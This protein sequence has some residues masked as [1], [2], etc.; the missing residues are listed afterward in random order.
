MFSKG[1]GLENSDNTLHN[2]PNICMCVFTFHWLCPH[3]WADVAHWLY[4]L[5]RGQKGLWNLCY[6]NSSS[7]PLSTQLCHVTHKHNYRVWWQFIPAENS[8]LCQEPASWHL[9][10]HIFYKYIITFTLKVPNIFNLIQLQ[11]TAS[12]IVADIFMSFST[13]H[14]SLIHLFGVT[15]LIKATKSQI[16]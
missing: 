9:T 16:S 4:R 11:T 15:N 2:K 10:K 7:H 3:A 14:C 5:R 8:N 6:S 1:V 12:E 13:T